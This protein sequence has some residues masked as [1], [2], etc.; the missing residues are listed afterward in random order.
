MRGLDVSAHPSRKPAAHVEGE[1]GYTRDFIAPY[2]LAVLYP[3]GLTRS[4]QVTLGLVSLLI[5]VIVYSRV[6]TCER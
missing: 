4:R 1:T 2:L 3:E 5:N 6:L